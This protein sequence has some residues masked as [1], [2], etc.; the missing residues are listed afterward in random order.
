MA[1]LETTTRGAVALLCLLPAM[2]TGN[3]L[4]PYAGLEERESES[5]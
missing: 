3:E 5:G 2:V 1:R 4:S